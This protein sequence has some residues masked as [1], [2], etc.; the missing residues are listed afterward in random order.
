[1]C[2]ALRRNRGAGSIVRLSNRINGANFERVISGDTTAEGNTG[3]DDES[4]T[5]TNLFEVLNECR[6]QRSAQWGKMKRL[7]Q[8]KKELIDTIGVPSWCIELYCSD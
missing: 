6:V 8:S 1:M 4:P 2:Q 7:L 5:A 3:V